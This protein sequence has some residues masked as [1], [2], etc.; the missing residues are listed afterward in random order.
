MGD[1]SRLARAWNVFAHDHPERSMRVVITA[2]TDQATGRSGQ[3]TWF[4]TL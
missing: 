2:S 3:R 1:M 4:S